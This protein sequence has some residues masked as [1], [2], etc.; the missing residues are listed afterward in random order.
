MNINQKQNILNSIE[1]INNLNLIDLL[2]QAYPNEG[3]ATKIIIGNFNAAQLIQ[4]IN[5]INKQL[6]NELNNGIGLLLPQSHNF[7]NDFGS[8]NLEVDLSNMA[9]WLSSA[10]FNSAASRVESLIYYQILNGFW[11]KPQTEA[12]NSKPETE[13]LT[14]ELDVIQGKLKNYIDKN[15]TLIQNLEKAT[16]DVTVFIESKRREFTTLTENQNTSTSTLQSINEVLTRA[17]SIEGDLKTLLQ[18]Q[19]TSADDAQRSIEVNQKSF[20]V[21]NATLTDLQKSLKETLDVAKTDLQTIGESKKEIESRITES[22][23]LLGLSADAALGGKFSIREG[24]VAKSLVWWRVAVG[25]SVALAVTWS[26]VVFLCLAT[27]TSLPYLDIIVNL[28]KTSPGFIL[29]GYIMAQYNKERAIEEEYAFRSAISETINAYADLLA[30]HDGQNSADTSRQT[31]LLDAIK[32]VYAKPQ[33]HKEA[34]PKN[35][36]KNSSKE[37]LEVLKDLAK[38]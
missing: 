36:Y 13:R 1:Q 35:F 17:T 27:H 38:K 24:K 20:S 29:M 8:V 7:N 16:N 10:D 32:Q 37:L 33:M 14:K 26:V 22:K 21:L 19:T 18:N 4:L 25:A 28:V 31:M 12:S 34:D 5:R 15:A 23:R 30:G 2:N 6:K 9:A 3:D 11:D